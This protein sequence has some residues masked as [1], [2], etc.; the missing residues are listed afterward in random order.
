MTPRQKLDAKARKLR[1]EKRDLATTLGTI[2]LSEDSAAKADE[3]RAAQERIIA[4]NGE[5]NEA[6]TAL[7]GMPVERFEARGEAAEYDRMF[8]GARMSHIVAHVGGGA[9]PDGATGELQAHYG[10]PANRV[11]VQMLFRPERRSAGRED[12]AVTAAPSDVGAIEGE[13]L[14]PPVPDSLGEYWGVVRPVVDS[15]DY[16]PPVLT[17]AGVVRGPH[18][19]SEVSAETDGN[20]AADA[21]PPQRLDVS[22]VGRAT[23]FARFAGMQG[24]L[25]EACGRALSEALD[26]QAVAAVESADVARDD[27]GGADTFASVFSRFIYPQIDGR[28]AVQESDLRLLLGNDTLADWATLYRNNNTDDN[29]VKIARELVGGIRVSPLIAAEASGANKRDVIVRKGTRRDVVQPVWQGVQLIVD[30]TTGRAKGE[31]T[32]SAR[33]ITNR[34]V[35]RAAGFARVEAQHS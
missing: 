26:A 1:R 23:D 35:I 15:G 18:D 14:I 17:T 12:R 34:K 30:E 11:P 10:V 9:V 5:L 32:I 3:S 21:L 27:A 28:Y 19:E 4:I 8:A 31:V 29:A 16:V 13:V 6:E 22:F 33:V 25:E 20:F 24:A 2:A 7:E